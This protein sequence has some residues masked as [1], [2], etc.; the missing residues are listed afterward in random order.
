MILCADDYGISPGVS[1]GIRQL[2]ARGRLS[3]TSCM[4][5][6]PGVEEDMREL[7]AYRESVDIGLHFVLTDHTPVS[8]PSGASGLL[9]ANDR[10]L[11]FRRLA[12]N[13][14]R[15]R[16][17]QR[18]IE[19]ELTSQLDRFVQWLGFPPDFIDGHQHVQQLPVVRNA[20]I[21]VVRADPRLA[22]AYVRVGTLPP[23]PPRAL[24]SSPSWSTLLGS[25]AIAL[26][27]RG[28]RRAFGAAGIRTNGCLLGY[29]PA[30]RDLVFEAVFAWYASLRPS[31]RDV[32]SCHPGM[33]D[34]ILEARDS[35]T[36]AREDVLG[37]LASTAFEEQLATS[38]LVLNRFDDGADVRPDGHAGRRPESC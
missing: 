1:S 21:E 23:L 15:G 37:F 19:R 30:Q 24:A 9:D 28:A 13:A 32:F 20:L 33:M 36:S 14:Y 27:S 35:L 38:G 25:C 3:A 31:A 6:F 16:L 34:P 10:L 11:P 29:Y 2:L 22:R 8:S 7:S 4:V 17:D 26:P 18:A 5:V 12:G